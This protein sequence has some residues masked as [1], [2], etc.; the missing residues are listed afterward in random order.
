MRIMDGLSNRADR[1]I[2][3]SECSLVTLVTQPGCLIS[4][5][6]A[7]APALTGRPDQARAIV[8][9]LRLIGRQTVQQ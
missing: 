3:A 6:L 4:C 7:L 2:G 8:L 1:V 5:T 9:Q